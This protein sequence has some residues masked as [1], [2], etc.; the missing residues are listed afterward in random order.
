MS[1]KST[2]PT[3]KAGGFDCPRCGRNSHQD[4]TLLQF[5]HW[6]GDGELFEFVDG[7]KLATVPTTVLASMPRLAST[8]SEERVEQMREE[9]WSDWGQAWW[10]SWCYSCNHASVW[11]GG[12]LIYPRTSTLPMPHEA[13]PQDAR[14]LYEEARE[15]YAVSPRAGA[16]LARATLERLLRTI[17]PEAGNVN[18]E[19]RIERVIDR[20]ST[21]LGQDLTVL[22]HVGNKSVHVEDDPDELTVL[23][24]SDDQTEV[25]GFLFDAINGLVDELIARPA[26][27]KDRFARLPDT[28]RSKVEARMAT[29]EDGHD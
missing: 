9:A 23:V 2:T 17:D 28:I 16:A 11:R 20:V 19:K 5:F 10:A 1:P 15:V 26:A 6:E 22:R 18:L 7:P 25:A 24:I 12:R 14:E 27:T 29:K 13:M 21:P 3:F 8:A 4:W